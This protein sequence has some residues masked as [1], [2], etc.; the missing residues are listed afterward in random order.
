MTYVYVGG[1]SRSIRCIDNVLMQ[2]AIFSFEVDCI[3]DRVR[4]KEALGWKSLKA[5]AFRLLWLRQFHLSS[6]FIFIRTGTS[7]FVSYL[8]LIWLRSFRYHLIAT[9]MI[10]ADAV[11]LSKGYRNDGASTRGLSQD[12]WAW[13]RLA[14]CWTSLALAFSGTIFRSLG[15]L[16]LACAFGVFKIIAHFVTVTTFYSRLGRVV[17][18]KLCLR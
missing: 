2:A 16:A 11:I 18:A 17:T 1:G 14:S 6:L 4:S 8:R 10:S 7:T 3:C 9:F 5:L 15:K 12:R 13:W